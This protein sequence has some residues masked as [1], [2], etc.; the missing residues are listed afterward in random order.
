MNLIMCKTDTPINHMNKIFYDETNVSINLRYDFN[1]YNPEILLSG[2]VENIIEF[3][4]FKFVDL[5]R[6]YYVNNFEI[7]NNKLVKFYLDC[8]LLETY[9]DGILNSKAILNRK[10]RPDDVQTINILT[11]N[12]YDLE[13]VYSNV[14]ATNTP[15]NIMSVIGVES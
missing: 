7:V 14:E 3:N 13:K 9:K 1:I 10:L 2:S 11:S 5:G 15:I 12:G 6:F 4:Y 8:D